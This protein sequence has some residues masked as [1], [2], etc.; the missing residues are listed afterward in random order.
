MV[1]KF[2]E[3]KKTNL[4]RNHLNMGGANPNGERI[5]VTNLY[6]E[7]NNKPWIAVM[8]EYHFSRAKSSE[9]YEE[10]C[11]MKAGGITTVSTYLFWIYHEEIEGEFD[12]SGDLDIR[13]FVKDA[14]RAGLDV[15]IRIGPWAHGEC[16]NGGFPDWL[17]KKAYKLRDNNSEYMTKTRIWYEKIYEQV[18]DLFYKD[19]GN[20]IGVQLENEFVNNAE[21]LAE[22]KKLAVEIG[23]DVPIYTV[24]G[25]NSAA[26]AKIPVDEVVPVFGGYIEAPWENHTNRLKPSSHYFFNKMRNDSAIGTDL[27]PAEISSDQWQLP[28]EKYPFATCEL[29]GG[30]QVTH[31]RRPIIMPMDIY[32]LSLVK[33]GCGNNLVGY[34]MYHG[35][36]NKIGKLSTFN[37]SKATGYPNDYSIIGYDFQAPLTQYGETNKQYG[38]LNMLHLFVQDFDE[39][40]APM[41]AV[42]AESFVSRDDKTSLRYGMRTDGKSGFVFV[43]HY[44]RLDALEDIKNAVIDTGVVTF[45]AIDVCGEICFFMPFNMK[46]GENTLEYA[47]AQP[48]CKLGDTYFFSA[49]DNIKP[50]YKFADGTVFTPNAGLDSAFDFGGIKVVTLT[51]EQA[52]YARKLSGKLYIGDNCDL[53][54]ADGKLCVVQNGSYSYNVWNGSGFDE[55]TVEREFVNAEISFEDIDELF[56]PPY[57]EELNI[58]G[59]RKRTWKKIS[60]T[61]DN[62]F[63]EIPFECDVAQIYT[64]GELVA[65]N[66]YYGKAWRI[67]AKLVYGKE[68]YLVMSEM[69]DDFYREF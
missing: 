3:Y 36:T 16:R 46:L 2:K 65:D 52:Q 69:K 43:N 58:G 33:I 68:C 60:T 13:K 4:I 57:V 39:I 59:E 9:W 14:E 67:P 32:A 26:G 66:F 29:G 50:E 19:G 5:D 44:Q 31:H 51:F 10:L 27:I 55:T 54:E 64:D 28:Y 11:K 18:K 40:L 42:D 25:W 49:I 20:I 38:M 15:V 45:P 23:Y 24:T 21:H 6:F 17:L 47:T 12:F 63:V 56:T 53:Y 22:L 7:R 8:A 41:E 30:I 62:G 35:G 61:S 48:L 1:Y 37:E 34:Y